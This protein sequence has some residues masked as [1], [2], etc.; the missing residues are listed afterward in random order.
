MARSNAETVD[1]YLAELGPV[2]RDAMALVRNTILEH[3]PDGYQEAMNYGMISYEI[4]LET[5]PK[6][7]NKK[8]LQYAALS[9]QKNY[10]SLY[11]MNVYGDK[12][13]ETCFL[14]EYEKTGKKLDMG[15]S[16]VRFKTLGDL[17]IELIGDAI[18]RTPVATFLERYEAVKG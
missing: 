15:K 13:T 2:R 16:C 10:M 4:P 14:D 9:S 6:T 8:P 17:P 1:E 18:A 7:Y 3:L 11:L 12:D 5:F